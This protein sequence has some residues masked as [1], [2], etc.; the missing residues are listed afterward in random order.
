MILLS[1]MKS[2]GLPQQIES[3]E[4]SDRSSAGTFGPHEEHLLDTDQLQLP[5]ILLLF[6]KLR[7][8]E[9]IG[10]QQA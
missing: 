5:P 8:N 2:S 7:E 10:P 1:S 9:K 4:I 6:M 3:P